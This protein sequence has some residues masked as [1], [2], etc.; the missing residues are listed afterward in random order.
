MILRNLLQDLVMRLLHGWWARTIFIH[1]WIITSKRVSAANE[2]ACNNSRVN[3]NR[4]REPTMML[5]VYYISTE[6][7]FTITK[8]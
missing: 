5:L 6:I 7:S 1:E 4:I 8:F 2:W 3:K